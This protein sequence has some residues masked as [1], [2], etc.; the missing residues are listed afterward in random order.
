MK[1]NPINI[2]GLPA[3]PT[4]PHRMVLEARLYPHQF[5]EQERRTEDAVLCV[6]VRTD[7]EDS[8]GHSVLIQK[9]DVAGLITQLGEHLN[10]MADAPE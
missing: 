1:I 4:T 3:N 9:E 6:T 10:R 5:P 2:S 8:K 7:T